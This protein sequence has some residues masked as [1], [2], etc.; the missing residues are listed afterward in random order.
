VR[1][2]WLGSWAGMFASLPRLVRWLIWLLIAVA[3]IILL[4]WILHLAGG[5]DWRIKVGHFH[6]NVG[7]T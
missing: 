1:K 6:W 5:A 3:V 2:D 4:A 7:V